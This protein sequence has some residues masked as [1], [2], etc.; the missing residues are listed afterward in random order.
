MAAP[1]VIEHFN[2]VEQ[3]HLASPQL[4][5]RSAT[6][7]LTLEKKLS[8]TALSSQ[9]PRRL[10]LQVIPFASRRL[11]NLRSRTCSPSRSDGGDRRRGTVASAPSQAP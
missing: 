7:L 4:S 1:L 10:M 9:L 5:K 2:V 8:I 11:G 6:S 3:L